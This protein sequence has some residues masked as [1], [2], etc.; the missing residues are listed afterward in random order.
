MKRYC[1]CLCALLMTACTAEK[2]PVRELPDTGK[3]ALHAVQSERLRNLMM[4][5]NDLMF[6]RMQ[7]EVALDRERRQLAG[8]I[9]AASAIMLATVKDIP[10]ALPALSLDSK[11]RQSFLN[12]SA[13]LEEQVTLLKQEAELNYVDAIP[14]RLERIVATCNACHQSFRKLPGK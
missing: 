6:E 1:H 12:L 9:A 7:T 2:H 11:E 5:L 8:E 10:Q 4:Q 3:P 13:R 14:Q